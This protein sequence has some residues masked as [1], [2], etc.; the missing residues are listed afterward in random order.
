MKVSSVSQ[1]VGVMK[2]RSVS[3]CYESPQC[4]L[5]L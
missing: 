3:R 1:F 2:V 5:V 4:E